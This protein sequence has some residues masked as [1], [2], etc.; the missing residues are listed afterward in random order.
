MLEPPSELQRTAS[1]QAF[2]FTFELSWK[3][4]QAVLGD[5][6]VPVATPRAA[7][8]AAADAGLVHDA[9]RWMTHVSSRN[10]TS[11]AYADSVA[12]DVYARFATGFADDVRDLLARTAAA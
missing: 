4:L 7:F 8:R 9:E 12:A 3:H 10:L 6:G 5:A 11:H 2:E 1:I